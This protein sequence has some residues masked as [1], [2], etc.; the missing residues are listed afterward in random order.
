MGSPVSV[1]L[2]LDYSVNVSY[3]GETH[4]SGPNTYGG[5][6]YRLQAP[7]TVGTANDEPVL[8]YD[9][10]PDHWV[11]SQMFDAPSAVTA[12]PA[13]AVGTVDSGY[14][15]WLYF[16]TGRYMS[17]QD[18]TDTTT[19]QYLFGVKDPY[20]NSLLDTTDRDTL[21]SSEPFTKDYLFETTDVKV[22][23]DGTVTGTGTPEVAATFDELKVM[24]NFGST[25]EVGWYKALDSSE[26]I[27]SKPS[28]LGG[29]L[30]APSFV[31]NEDVCGF[32]GDSYLHALY[33]ETGTA[34]VKSVVGVE[35]D[36]RVKDKIKLGVG[37]SSSLGIHVGRKSGAKGFVQQ[38][39]G[40]INQID[41]T[42]AFSVKSGFV[43]WRE[44]R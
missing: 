23:T 18:K 31:P 4:A 39:T 32:G 30:L 8:L 40:T 6:L 7:A 44:V 21:L 10:D 37:I 27:V 34:Y 11:L 9:V 13:A 38:S 41:L 29:I 24:Q 14:S 36:D 12:A 35:A 26:R 2:S 16:G 17:A 3:I 42:P 28:V 43:N 22:Y 19:E 1:D 25:Y 33:F 20:Y 5:G 15:L